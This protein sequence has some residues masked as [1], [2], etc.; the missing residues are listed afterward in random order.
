[1]IKNIKLR[2]SSSHNWVHLVELLP[3]LRFF[4]YMRRALF[5]ASYSEIQAIFSSDYARLRRVLYAQT[6]KE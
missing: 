4:G 1:M 3:Q 5:T 6:T 2:K